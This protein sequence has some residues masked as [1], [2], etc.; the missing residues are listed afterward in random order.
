MRLKIGETLRGFRLKMGMKRLIAQCLVFGA[1]LCSCHAQPKSDTIK[2]YKRRKEAICL[3]HSKN[4][5]NTQPKAA[6]K[7]LIAMLQEEGYIIDN[8]SEEL[9]FLTAIKQQ[10]D[11]AVLDDKAD[12]STLELSVQV[13]SQNEGSLIKIN[14]MGKSFDGGGM[15]T[16]LVPMHEENVYDAF[17]GKLGKRLNIA[18][19]TKENPNQS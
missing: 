13:L 5:S 9:G 3:N 11:E 14:F 8:F 17:F 10:P 15:V 18:K 4:F 6:M 7:A 2:P 12:F 16:S 19:L 1:L